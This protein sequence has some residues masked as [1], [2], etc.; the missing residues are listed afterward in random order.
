MWFQKTFRLDGVEASDPTER[1]L[2]IAAW[3][4]ELERVN[5]PERVTIINTLVTER[6]LIAVAFVTETITE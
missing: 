6:H 4:N 5:H 3:L 2:S 1:P